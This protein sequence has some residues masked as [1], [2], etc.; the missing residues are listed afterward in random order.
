ML[1]HASNL[2][3]ASALSSWNMSSDLHNQALPAVMKFRI[4]L[5]ISILSARYSVVYE[6]PNS[7]LKSRNGHDTDSMALQ[8]KLGWLQFSRIGD[9]LWR[10]R[11]ARTHL[12]ET[13]I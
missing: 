8:D 7:D 10:K 11:R 1:R 4:N 2:P 6:Q 3:F 5:E 13:A 9:L 12:S